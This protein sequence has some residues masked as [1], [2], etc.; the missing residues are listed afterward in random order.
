VEHLY[1]ALLLVFTGYKPKLH[2]LE[3]LGRL[4]GGF[5]KELLTIFPSTTEEKRNRFQL[6]K[7]AYTEAR[8]EPAY[9]I[10]KED[11]EYLPPASESF[12]KQSSCCASSASPV[13]KRKLKSGERA[14]SNLEY[15]LSTV[16]VFQG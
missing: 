16:L 5:G 15:S 7:K 8:Y 6:L 1:H 14:G 2:D 4:T 3:K 13:M 11:L 12:R 10:E 9:R